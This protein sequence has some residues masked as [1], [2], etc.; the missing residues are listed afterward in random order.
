MPFQSISNS[1]SKP[2]VVGSTEAKVALTNGCETKEECRLQLETNTKCSKTGGLVTAAP[3]PTNEP[4]G[5]DSLNSDADVE[6]MAPS[7]LESSNAC[8]SSGTLGSEPPTPKDGVNGIVASPPP[9]PHNTP[10][11]I[12]VSILQVKKYM[13]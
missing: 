12:S 4:V 13:R 2:V 3:S 9:T 1:K 7:P 10:K 5:S 11:T 8:N 6:I